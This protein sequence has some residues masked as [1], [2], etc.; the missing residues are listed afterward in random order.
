MSRTLEACLRLYDKDLVTGTR[1]VPNRQLLARLTTFVRTLPDPTHDMGICVGAFLF[2]QICTPFVYITLDSIWKTW[3]THLYGDIVTPVKAGTTPPIQHRDILQD[4]LRYLLG[5]TTLIA[6]EAIVPWSPLRPISTDVTTVSVAFIPSTPHW[7][8]DNLVVVKNHVVRVMTG[9][10]TTRHAYH[11]AEGAWKELFILH[12]LREGGVHDIP[13]LFGVRVDVDILSLLLEHVP[14]RFVD[15]FPVHHRC[16]LPLAA[17]TMSALLTGIQSLHRCGIA[18][19]DLK[20]ENIMF[21]SNGA[22]VL[23]DFDSADWIGTLF[24][25]ADIGTY[26]FQDPVLTTHARS[27]THLPTNVPY[28]YRYQDLFACG[29]LFAAMFHLDIHALQ[30]AVARGYVDTPIVTTVM[31]NMLPTQVREQLG[32]QGLAF[33]VQ[34][35]LVETVDRTTSPTATIERLLGHPF[36]HMD[37]TWDRGL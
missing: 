8:G 29:C 26:P 3:T 30:L 34:V 19:R 37:H 33:L 12:Q 17:H 9:T 18:H 2:L 25:P 13:R 27:G 36:L 21:R 31:V 4:L 23:I 32:P 28:D 5:T 10:G 16:Y 22:P 24:R 35:L 20:T 7:T 11:L 1:S 14:M 6:A 15:M